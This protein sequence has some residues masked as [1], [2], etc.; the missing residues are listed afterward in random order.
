MSAADDAKRS[1]SSRTINVI[2]ADGTPATLPY[3]QA[4][5]LLSLGRA[6]RAATDAP[7]KRAAKKARS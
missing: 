6:T 1:E 7:K 5:G 3:R 2:L 4:V